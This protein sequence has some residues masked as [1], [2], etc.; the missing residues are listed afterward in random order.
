MDDT[1]NFA[2]L[3]RKNL[4]Y[5]QPPPQI[6]NTIISKEEINESSDWAAEENISKKGLKNLAVLLLRTIHKK[7]FSSHREV[8]EEI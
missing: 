6:I 1:I 2:N 7:Q 8:A 5:P 4:G 3:D